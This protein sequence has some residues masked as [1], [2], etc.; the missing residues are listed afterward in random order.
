MSSDCTPIFD[1]LTQ[2]LVTEILIRLP[3]KSILCCK[4][5]SKT[6]LSQISNPNFIKSHLNHT[7]TTPGSDQTLI[8]NGGRKTMSLLHLDSC[9]IA[10]S[11][12]DFPFE[13]NIYF[14]TAGC[15][16]GIICFW[17][18]PDFDRVKNPYTYLWNP[19]TKQAKLIPPHNIHFDKITMVCFGF[20]F[21]PIGNDYKVVALLACFGKP[22][23]A[24]VYSANTNVWRRVE[25][26]PKDLP[27]YGD[28]DVCVNGYLCCMGTYGMLAFDLN[29]EV[30]TSH[31]KLPKCFWPVRITD[32]NDYI[33]V[34][35]SKEYDLNDVFNLW[36]LDDEACLRDSGVEASWTLMLCIDVGRRV[37]FVFGYFNSGDFL[38]HAEEDH[39]WI[40]YNT[41]KKETRNFPVSLHDGRTLKYNESLV[42]INGFKQLNLLACEDDS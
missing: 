40:L 38:L 36:K 16:N 33:S 34:T 25:P 20:G 3:V 39:A 14:K 35:A 15:C 28:L 1:I 5:V 32:F 9:A 27:S 8:L 6:W 2:D 42:S 4:S 10:T 37:D 22:W 7:L 21:D 24:E 12:F 11:L 26:N 23:T 29:K 17:H 18:A 41:D 13:L 31:I 19:A 30:F